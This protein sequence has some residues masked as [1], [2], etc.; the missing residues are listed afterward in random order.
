MKL[1]PIPQITKVYGDSLEHVLWTWED[2]IKKL[3]VIVADDLDDKGLSTVK[4]THHYNSSSP[5]P[6]HQASYTPHTTTQL[7]DRSS[8]ALKNIY[9][10][11]VEG[12]I[13]RG[14]APP[15]YASS[16]DALLENLIPQ[17]PDRH[18]L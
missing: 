2:I 12:H 13:N 18:I 9:A 14:N 6:R 10:T 11:T 17:R 8:R 16:L 1:S 4:S 5:Q 7:F 15:R 3:R